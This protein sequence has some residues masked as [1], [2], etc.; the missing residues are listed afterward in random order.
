VRLLVN[1]TVRDTTGDEVLVAGVGGTVEANGVWT[2][3]VIDAIHIELQGSV[4]K[5]AYTSG[6]TATDVTEKP[7]GVN[8]Q[9]AISCSKSAGLRY[10]NPS[11]R[12]LAPQG[13]INRT[14]VTVKNRGQSGPMGVRWRIDI[15]D[16]VYRG[17]KG[18]TMSQNPTEVAP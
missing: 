5:N 1:Q 17:F 15:T 6:G 3:T 8:P 11:I 9:C 13:S 12:S 2:M 18:A 14:R 4:Y 7:G 10:D 16:P